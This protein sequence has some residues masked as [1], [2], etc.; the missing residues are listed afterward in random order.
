MRGGLRQYRH[1]GEVVHPAG[2]QVP[3]LVTSELVQQQ[4]QAWYGVV[5]GVLWE[6]REKISIDS[7][8]RKPKEGAFSSCIS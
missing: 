6:W 7:T 2:R 5:C 4:A 8:R 1:G 3:L